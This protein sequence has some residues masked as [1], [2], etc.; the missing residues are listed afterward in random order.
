M[1][2]IK[3]Q[4]CLQTF[5]NFNSLLPHIPTAFYLNH[6]NSVLLV[7]SNKVQRHGYIYLTICYNVMSFLVG[8]R[9][10]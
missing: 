10:N 9:R 6:Y 1:W 4:L 2:N 7:A 3:D 5:R 8:S